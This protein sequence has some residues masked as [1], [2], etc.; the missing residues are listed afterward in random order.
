M[1]CKNSALSGCVGVSRLMCQCQVCFSIS[2]L[3]C[4]CIRVSGLLCH[5]QWASASFS[6]GFCVIFSGLLCHFQWASVS[7]LLMFQWAS[8]S[9][10]QYQV[11]FC[12]SVGVPQ[13]PVLNRHA[14]LNVRLGKIVFFLSIL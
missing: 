7:I 4:Q 5:F 6:V 10:S 8:V 9:V 14:C 2:G 12:V 13:S 11:Y 3:R 1:V